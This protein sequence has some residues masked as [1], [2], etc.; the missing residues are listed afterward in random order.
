LTPRMYGYAC[1][2]PGMRAADLSAV[3]RRLAGYARGHG[4]AL[5]EFYVLERSGYE[6]LEVWRE[7]LASCQA[8]RV[9]DIVIPSLDHLHATEVLAR[10][11][12]DDV[13]R[14]IRGHVWIV[15]E[16]R[17]ALTGADSASGVIGR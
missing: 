5:D 2:L 11:A 6:R 3:R 14:S 15:D 8:F 4:F 16:P 10:F 7:L 1:R 13:A 17:P 12:R 9:R